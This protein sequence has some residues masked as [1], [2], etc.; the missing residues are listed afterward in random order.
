MVTRAIW[1]FIVLQAATVVAIILFLRMLLH[2]QLEVGVKRIQKLDQENL[3]KE[4]ELNKKLQ[5]LDRE[6]K[7][8]IEEARRETKSM[9]ETAKE[10]VKKMREE[11]QIKAK[12]AAKRT[13]ASALR[14]KEKLKRETE[15]EAFNKGI[16]LS[17]LILK[18]IFS[19]NELKDFRCKVSRE[20][21]D[22]LINSKQ[23]D[24]SL[25]KNKAPEVITADPLPDEEKK[26]IVKI[27][28]KKSGG[29]TKVTFT[30]DKSALGGIVLKIDE[31][32]IDGSI[33]YRVDKA[34][35]EMRE[36]LK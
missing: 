9:I 7:D 3:K 22:T 11:E 4:T 13:I 23:I 16:D 27:I 29:K 21:I 31:Q 18:R 34:A 20:V 8:K 36:G 15:R 17:T 33:A 2:K 30:V 24:E 25:Q 1:P 19:E 6:Y 14:E 10:E 26:H 28:E 5:E 32:I 12:E 35:M